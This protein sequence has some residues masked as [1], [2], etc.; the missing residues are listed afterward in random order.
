MK[1]ILQDRYGSPDQA[2][3]VGDIPAPEAGPGQVLVRVRA[4]S[5][6]PDVWHVV[7]GRPFVLRL[8]GSGLGRPKNP[9]PG[10]DLAGQVE[11]VGPG[12]TRFRPGDRV[13]GEAHARMQWVNGGTFAELAAVPEDCLAPIPDG[14]SFEAAACVPT[15]GYIALHNL[16]NEGRLE[17]G[18]RVLINGAG[19]GVGTMALQLAK[20][21]GARVTAVDEAGKLEMLRRLGAD[22]VIDYRSE[23]ATRGTE[24]YDLVFDVASTLP[25]DGARRILEAE[26]KYVLIGHDHYGKGAGRVFGSL[27]RFAKLAFLS[28][29]DR[30]LP[31]PSAKMPGKAETMAV[32]R[33]LLAAGKLTP[34]VGKVFPLEEFSAA[35][36]CLETGGAVGRIVMGVP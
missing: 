20:A 31:R 7:T 18:H 21:F 28:L 24:R 2:L 16:R 23:D 5:L 6:H 30:R 1:A 35:F 22:R 4:A 25:L 19:G 26:G 34:P 11:A 13:F 3:R 29:F 14:V 12:V 8:M 15:S 17:A 33:E 36:R 10:T 32:L 27:P 9:V